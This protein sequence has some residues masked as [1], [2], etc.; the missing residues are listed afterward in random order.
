M[1]RVWERRQL[2]LHYERRWK[3]AQKCCAWE[4]QLTERGIPGERE[5]MQEEVPGQIRLGVGT[6]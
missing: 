4:L 6:G 1:R 3:K 2:P 5:V